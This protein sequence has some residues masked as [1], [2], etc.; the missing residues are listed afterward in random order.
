MITCTIYYIVYIC[1][2]QGP[3]QGKE[4]GPVQVLNA[5]KSITLISLNV[6]SFEKDGS[7][8]FIS[9]LNS[10]NVLYLRY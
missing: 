6:Y 8:D 9:L 1:K 7:W 4:K 5:F 3:E 2:R 10:H